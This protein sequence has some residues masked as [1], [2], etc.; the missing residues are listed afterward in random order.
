MWLRGASAW[1]SA[2]LAIVAFAAGAAWAG[3]LGLAALVANGESMIRL[4]VRF[5]GGPVALRLRWFA[6][7]L[8]LLAPFVVASKG[9]RG[10]VWRGRAYDLRG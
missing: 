2:I 7:A 1:L 6:V 8:F 3:L 4:H 10:V 9:W 5:G